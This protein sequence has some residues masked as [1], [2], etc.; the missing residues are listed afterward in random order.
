[1]E[2]SSC[3]PIVFVAAVIALAI[4]ALTPARPT[5]A[6]EAKPAPGTAAEDEKIHITADMLT[7]DS[8]ARFAEFT[9][10]VNARQGKTVIIADSLKIFYRQASGQQKDAEAVAAAIERI[11]A[12]GNVRIT[13]DDKTA[14]T[15]QAVYTLDNRV[16]VLTGP[17]SRVTSGKDSI[18]GE[19]ITFDRTN[20]QIQVEGGDTRKQVEAVFFSGEKGLR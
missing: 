10:H 3:R 6:R 5:G 4:L 11:V 17:D 1:M 12:T 8:N 20:G 9:G 2:N 15:H 14:E 18:A 19:K 7:S 13:L 16:L